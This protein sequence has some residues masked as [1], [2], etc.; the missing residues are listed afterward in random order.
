KALDLRRD[1][2][3]A[4]H[5]A[6]SVNTMQAGDAR[7][8]G[9]GVEET[10]PEVIRDY[11]GAFAEHAQLEPPSELHLFGVDVSDIVL[12]RVAGDVLVIESWREDRGVSRVERR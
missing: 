1:P 5:S 8:S 2:R 4:L 10:D 12:V 11:L 7:I 6:S 3:L 9:R